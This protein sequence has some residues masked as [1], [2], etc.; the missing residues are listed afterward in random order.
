MSSTSYTPL[1][2]PDTDEP[3]TPLSVDDELRMAQ[4]TL[5]KVGSYNIHDHMQM[6]RAAVALDD[7][8]RSLIS[9]LDAERGE[10]P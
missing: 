3:L 8:M 7:R 5:E 2:N 1:F 10:R 6:I 4:Q 9:A